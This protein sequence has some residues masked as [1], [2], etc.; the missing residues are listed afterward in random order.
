MGANLSRAIPRDKRTR[1]LP[2]PPRLRVCSERPTEAHER[3]VATVLGS[4]PSPETA[5]PDRTASLP[6]YAAAVGELILHLRDEGTVLSSIDQHLVAG[7][8]EAG[9]PLGPV[10]LAVREGAERL[11]RRKN[12]PRGLPLSALRASV[13]RAGAR[14]RERMAAGQVGLDQSPL[15]EGRRLLEV[16]RARIAAADE[17]SRPDRLR[18]LGEA[19]RRLAE[20]SAEDPAGAFVALLAVSRCYYDGLFELLE[21]GDRARLHAE[22]REELGSGLARMAPE[23]VHGATQELIRRYMRAADP[24]LDPIEIEQETETD[25]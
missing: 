18:L 2:R 21:P 15:D 22:V 19:E 1:H 8:W 16:A 9:Y 10:L 5:V 24:I 17:G 7:W 25:E 11:K 20:V 4:G 3:G 12:P 13:E 6:E 14:A 23:A